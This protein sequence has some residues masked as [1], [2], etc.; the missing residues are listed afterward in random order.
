VLLTH[1]Q[2]L[3]SQGRATG[4]EAL[5]ETAR[6]IEAAF[7]PRLAWRTCSEL[8]AW[9]AAAAALRWQVAEEDAR[10]RLRLESRFACEGFTVSLDCR[11]EP[12]RVRRVGGSGAE[13]G[14]CDLPAHPAGR[15]PLPSGRYTW[16]AGRLTLCV[17][18]RETVCIEVAL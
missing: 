4:L 15:L 6:R 11:R 8:A 12:R 14:G 7:G 3:Y 1:W 10:L 5:A 13:G 18:L 9:T 17:G 16:R 2:S